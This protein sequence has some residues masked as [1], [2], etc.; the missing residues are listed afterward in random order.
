[1]EISFILMMGTYPFINQFRGRIILWL[2]FNRASSILA[3]PEERVKEDEKRRD[4]ESA[5]TAS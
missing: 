3:R 1:M 4:K 5:D 2:H